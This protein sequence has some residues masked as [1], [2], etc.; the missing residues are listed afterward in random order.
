MK[1][2]W[3][4]ESMGANLKDKTGMKSQLETHRKYWQRNVRE[5]KVQ[6]EPEA[7][8]YKES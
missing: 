8:V 6:W 3:E 7:T 2:Q 1:E 4:V 5:G